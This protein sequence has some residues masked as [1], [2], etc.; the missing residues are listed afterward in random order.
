MASSDGLRG[1]PVAMVQCN[2]E[3]KTSPDSDGHFDGALGC[4]RCRRADSGAIAARGGCKEG[5]NTFFKGETLEGGKLFVFIGHFKKALSSRVESILKT[6]LHNF[7]QRSFLINFMGMR[8]CRNIGPALA[9]HRVRPFIQL[10]RGTHHCR[11]M[12]SGV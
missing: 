2:A 5:T 1:S 3:A 12:T 4:R 11:S 7:M 10:I 8:C 6:G 9:S